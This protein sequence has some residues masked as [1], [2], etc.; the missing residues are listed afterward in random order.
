M[1]AAASKPALRDRSG[2]DALLE[3]ARAAA[4]AG[5]AVATSW[6]REPGRLRVEEKAASDD[7]VSQADR[8]AEA[9]I[10][11][12]LESHR[13][14]DAI[15]GEEAPGRDGTSGILWAVDPIDGTTNYLYG[16]ADWAVSVAAMDPLGQIL[17][18]AVEEPA[19][20]RLTEARLGGGTWTNGRRIRLDPSRDL[21]RALVEV[22]LGTPDQ[23]Q[24]ADALVAAL[25]P[26]VRDL[27]RGGSA[28]AALAQVATGRADAYWGPGLQRWDAAAGVLLVAEAGGVTGDASGERAGAWPASGNVLASR[29]GLF[30]PLQGLISPLYPSEST[31]H[32][33]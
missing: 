25:V 10:R 31:H 4:H 18:A 12:V 6:A 29:A 16:R 22:N 28:A 19:I 13:P 27:R 5:A 33:E 3:V 8:E 17:A 23:R 26:R 7:L 24:R 14:E 2:L 15:L 21:R 30:E 32:V 11:D 1:T 20:D 9:A